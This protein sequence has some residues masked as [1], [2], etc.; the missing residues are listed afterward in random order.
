M[1]FDQRMAKSARLLQVSPA[2]IIHIASGRKR[3]FLRFAP[4]RRKIKSYAAKTHLKK[5]TLKYQGGKKT[6]EKRT[7]QKHR[8]HR[9]R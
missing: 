9:T 8:H 2:V 6:D 4:R 1:G 3:H 7:H 5:S